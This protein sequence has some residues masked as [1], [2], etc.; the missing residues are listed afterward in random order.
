MEPG[1]NLNE[2][3]P[4][5]RLASPSE[6]F[7]TQVIRALIQLRIDLKN[8]KRTQLLEFEKNEELSLK[9]KNVGDGQE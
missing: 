8:E 2:V 6:E 5:M 4:D 9:G 3:K 1:G 7:E